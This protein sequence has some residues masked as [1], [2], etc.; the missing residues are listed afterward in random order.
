MGLDGGGGICDRSGG[1]SGQFGWSSVEAK[2]LDV[3]GK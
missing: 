2:D 3:Q 1:P